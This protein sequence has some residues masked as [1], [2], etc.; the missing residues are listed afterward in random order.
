MI[1]MESSSFKMSL[2]L[3]INR[4]QDKIQAEMGPEKKR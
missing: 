4:Q 2:S 1:G 3:L